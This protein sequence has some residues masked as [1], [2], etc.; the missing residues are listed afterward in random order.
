[1]AIPKLTT[2]GYLPAGVHDATLKDVKSWANGVP[3][4][5][6]RSALL[7]NLDLFLEE[8]IRPIGVYPIYLAGSFF[9]DK[10]KPGDIDFVLDVREC[11]DA[12]AIGMAMVELYANHK[13][14]K[15]KYEIDAYPNVAGNNDFTRFFA[16]IRPLEIA[17]RGLTP[18]ARR[19]IVRITKW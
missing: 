18:E 5:N 8:V 3:D 16:Y 7:R 17:S 13:K 1:M 11:T 12:K 15:E 6:R 4:M 2:H 14:N 10:Y 9:S 19:G